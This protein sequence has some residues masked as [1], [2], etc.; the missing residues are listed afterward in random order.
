MK[1]LLLFLVL[2]ALLTITLLAGYVTY[3]QIHANWGIVF[4]P[5]VALWIYYFYII[6]KYINE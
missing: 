3:L 5:L 4:I 2:I 1:L 6:E